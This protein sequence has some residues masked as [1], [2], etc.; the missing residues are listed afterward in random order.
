MVFDTM[1]GHLVF[2]F[3]V[4]WVNV[5]LS[6]RRTAEPGLTK[7]FHLFPNV[8]GIGLR[9]FLKSKYG[10]KVI[11]QKKSAYCPNNVDEDNSM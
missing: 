1:D 3:I 9:I 2:F 7:G 8:G 11:I 10:F 5:D 6:Y 4:G